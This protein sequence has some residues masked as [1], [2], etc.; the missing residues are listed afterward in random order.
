MAIISTIQDRGYVTLKAKFFYP[1][2]IGSLVTKLLKK[3]FPD[4][5][6]FNFTAKME[7][8]LD[9]IAQGKIEGQKIL[10]QFY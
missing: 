10:V 8:E 4:I 3:H 2:E 7:E 1:E 5:V 6:D 9:D